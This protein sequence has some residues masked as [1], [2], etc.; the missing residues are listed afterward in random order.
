VLFVKDDKLYVDFNDLSHHSVLVSDKP[1]PQSAAT[2][3]LKFD[4]NSAHD[5]TGSLFINDQVAR[6]QPLSTEHDP[7]A[8]GAIEVGQNTTSS[9]SPIY[10]DQQGFPYPADNLDHVTVRLLPAR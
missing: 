3:R 7:N 6:R 10:L 8:F 1:I 9:V 2:L 4:L 5:G